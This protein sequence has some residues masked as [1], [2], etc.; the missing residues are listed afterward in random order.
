MHTCSPRC[1]EVVNCCMGLQL[2]VILF[3]KF[4]CILGTVNTNSNKNMT[5]NDY[6][7]MEFKNQPFFNMKLAMQ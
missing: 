4:E 3:P 2:Y 1:R 7:G 6:F 5:I